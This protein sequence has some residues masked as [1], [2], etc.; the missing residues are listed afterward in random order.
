MGGPPACIFCICS[1]GSCLL[2]GCQPRTSV[3]ATL[4]HL[5]DLPHVCQDLLAGAAEGSRLR[6]H[7]YGT[8]GLEA[9]DPAAARKLWGLINPCHSCAVSCLWCTL[10]Q[11]VLPIP[12]AAATPAGQA[13]RP[14]CSHNQ[15][16][17][18]CRLTTLCHRPQHDEGFWARPGN[19]PEGAVV[20][21]RHQY[22]IVIQRQVVDDGP[23]LLQA[24]GQLSVPT[25]C[26]PRF[27]CYLS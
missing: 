7:M 21:A 27:L 16:Q 5:V 11:I 20:A 12:S 8:A 26:S 6:D 24:A 17:L 14:F 15:A 4:L 1:V 23:L 13:P 2:P 18:S 9:R 22:P 19:V 3:A 10:P 25:L